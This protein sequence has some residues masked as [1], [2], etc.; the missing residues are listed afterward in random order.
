MRK[1]A[2][3]LSAIFLTVMIVSFTSNSSNESGSSVD[4]VTIGNQVWMAE[5]LNVDTFRNGDPIP[6]SKTEEEWDEADANGLAAWCYY[7]N[8]PVNGLKYGKLYN[9]HAV[10]DPRG[11]APKG[12]HIPSDEEW[13]NLVYSLSNEDPDSLDIYGNSVGIK[14]KYKKCWK[15]YKPERG[16]GPQEK[17]VKK[18]ESKATNES[19][20]SGLPGGVSEGFFE[21]SGNGYHGSWWSSSKSS[22]SLDNNSSTLYFE[23]GDSWVSLSV[24]CVRD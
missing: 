18:R 22:W 21:F 20:F 13:T 3:F 10:N 14:M 24:R 4:E 2:L 16:D 19:G 5:N 6:H 1:V 7:E 15:R 23:D 12:W 17:T 8:D 11:L 9:W